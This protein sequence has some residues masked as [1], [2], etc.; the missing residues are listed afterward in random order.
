MAKFYET[1]EFKAER[2]KWYAK[3]EKS[4]FEDC[5]ILDDQGE[6]SR[7]FTVS[8]R[9]F[10]SQAEFLRRWD[11]NQE[12]LLELHRGLSWTVGDPTE[13]EAHRLYGNGASKRFICKALGL[14]SAKLNELL[15]MHIA[16]AVWND[17]E[18]DIPDGCDKPVLKDRW[19]G[20]QTQFTRKG[21]HGWNWKP[22]GGS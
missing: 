14:S 21:V 19:N 10:C 1:D 13:A 17:A 3:L 18:P 7:N 9:G 20:R 12:R 5:E 2:D 4:G 22:E 15:R 16:E 11:P 6:I 8:K